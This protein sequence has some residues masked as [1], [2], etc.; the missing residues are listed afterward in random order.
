[1]ELLIKDFEKLIVDWLKSGDENATN[2]AYSL[3]KQAEKAL[4]ID[5]VRK[6]YYCQN[7]DNGYKDSICIEQ[8]I[9]C[10]KVDDMQ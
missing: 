8:C 2:L 4:I 1:M 3:A 7:I 9:F 6:S 5:G 10:K